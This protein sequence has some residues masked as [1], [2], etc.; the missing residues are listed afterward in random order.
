M[1]GPGAEFFQ[2]GSERVGH[3]AVHRGRSGN[4][5]AGRVCA[6]RPVSICRG[7]GC[8]SSLST[9]TPIIP[10]LPDNYVSNT[11]VYTGTHDNTT[12]R[13][14][15]EDLPDDQRR[16]L[17][18]YLKRPE[19]AQPRCRAGVDGVGV[20]VRAALAMAPLQDLLNL[21][22]EARMNVPGRADGNWR[23][24]CTEDDAVRSGLRIAARF[25]KVFEPFGHDRDSN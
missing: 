15:F 12:T 3:A 23:W 9:A 13:G 4:D 25:N 24:R 18:N 6:A 1:P 21:G 20:V 10:H 17:W 7:C 2:R 22:N 19:G 11:V 8:C 14:W 5:H 16:N